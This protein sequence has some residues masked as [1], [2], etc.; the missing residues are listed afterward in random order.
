MG[1]ITTNKNE[2]MR[3]WLK[4]YINLMILKSI[5]PIEQKHIDEMREK[6]GEMHM[7]MM[8]FFDALGANPEAEA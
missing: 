4:L 3:R 6:L 8:G 1:E 5:L 7:Y 2:L